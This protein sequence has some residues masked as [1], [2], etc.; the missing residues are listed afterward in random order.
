MERRTNSL[1]AWKASWPDSFYGLSL[2]GRAVVVG[3][4]AAF[5]GFALDEIAHVLGYPWFSERLLEN[6]VEGL[7]IGYA[8]YWLSRSREQ[9]MQRRMKEIGFMNH[10]IRNAMQ[11]IELAAASVDDAQERLGMIQVAVRRVIDTLAKVTRETDEPLVVSAS[12]TSTSC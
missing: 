7:I 4:L 12:V 3:V 11:A 10:H 9:R 8:V 5:L 1:G 2:W 6:S